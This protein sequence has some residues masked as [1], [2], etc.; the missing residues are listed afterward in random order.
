MRRPG[1]ASVTQI[2]ALGEPAPPHLGVQ[3]RCAVRPPAEA[4]RDWWMRRYPRSQW[5]P[6]WTTAT[7]RGHHGSPRRT[8]PGLPG[9]HDLA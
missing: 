5:K 6:P 4:L 3:R 8:A 7:T 9:A 2:R 1:N